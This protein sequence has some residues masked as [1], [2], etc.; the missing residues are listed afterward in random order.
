[1]FDVIVSNPPYISALQKDV[2]ERNVLDFEPHIALFAPENDPLAFYRAIASFATTN[3][4]ENGN[5]YF[6]INEALPFETKEAIEKYGFIVEL[7]KDLN[8][9]F[10]MIK[11]SRHD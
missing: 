2:M 4:S 5:L 11:A 9:K 7:K 3:L 8:G 6:E 10:R 1:M